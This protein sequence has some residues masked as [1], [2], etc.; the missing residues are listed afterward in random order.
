MEKKQT[1]HI[2]EAHNQ[3]IRDATSSTVNTHRSPGE[4]E[5]AQRTR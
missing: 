1:D 5:A 3:A 2:Q 4:W